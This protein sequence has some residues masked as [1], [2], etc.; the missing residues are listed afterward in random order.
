[1][2][3]V[4]IMKKYLTNACK[5][6]NKQRRHL[7]FAMPAHVKLIISAELH[8]QFEKV[9]R[10]S[11]KLEEVL[12][13]LENDVIDIELLSVWDYKICFMILD[14]SFNSKD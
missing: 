11:H 4:I 8:V 7:H 9:S 1:M 6:M 5:Q 12:F 13:R 14:N 2:K 10:T 3:F